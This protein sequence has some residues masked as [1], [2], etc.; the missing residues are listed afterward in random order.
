MWVG[1][2]FFFL[3]LVVVCCF[4]GGVFDGCYLVLN[5]GVPFL[6]GKMDLTLVPLH[7]L[8]WVSCSVILV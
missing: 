8:R 1:G 7:P 3:F 4:V 5:I 2:F 6:R